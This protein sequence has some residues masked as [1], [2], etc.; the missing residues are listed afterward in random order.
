MHLGL[1]YKHVSP[2]NQH[3]ITIS[4]QIRLNVVIM[5][6]YSINERGVRDDY[7]PRFHCTFNY[8]LFYVW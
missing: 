7:I 1:E 5:K 4:T 8:S 2:L 6:A 3:V